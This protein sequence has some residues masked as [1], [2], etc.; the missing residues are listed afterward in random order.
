MKL[1][2]KTPIRYNVIGSH[3][4]SQMPEWKQ[5]EP[6]LRETIEVVAQVLPFRT[7]RYQMENLIDWSK[8]PND[9]IFQLVF[10]QRDMLETDHYREVARQLR[11]GASPDSLDCAIRRIRLDLNPHPGGQLTH[12]VPMLE[13]RP[14]WGVQHKYRET[15]LFFP[16]PGQTCHAFCTY[17]FR[18]AQFVGM[19]GLKF[20][21]RETTGLLAYLRAHPEVTDVLI[22]GGDPMIMRAKLL[23][24]YI[25]PLLSPEFEHVQ[26]IRIGT[27]AVASWPHR[28]VSDPDADD[29]LR[30]F[31]AVVAANRHLAIMGHYAHPV[32]LEPEVA[33]EAIRRIRGTGA[34]IRMQTPLVK[35]VNDAPEIW[36]SLWQTGVRLGLLPYYM[37]VERD[38]GT[39]NYFEVPLV[40][41]LE[42]CREAY[43]SVSGLSRSVQGPTMS[44][45]PGKVQILG[46]V[47][48]R[49]MMD[50][51]VIAALRATA[52]PVSTIDADEPVLVCDFIQARDPALVRKP[53]FAAFDPGATW[54]DHLRPAFLNDR[55]AFGGQAAP[56]DNFPLH[57]LTE[58]LLN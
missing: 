5:V 13:G 27:K 56:A 34:Q 28:F 1:Y 9:P 39:K 20:E 26:N 52:G 19:Q 30:L 50:D 24:K 40:R 3:N 6:D 37:F 46:M 53:F 11:K 15:I 38:T 57:A 31:E 12:N 25:E 33:R 42:I 16:S 32:E 23:R 48:L 18:W 35:H 41:A 55:F 47:T 21:S 36:S 51:R 2:V 58:S 10:P 8:V 43:A 17:C 29:C 45:F 44:A 14:L 54:F 4:L 7:N 49:E 22:T